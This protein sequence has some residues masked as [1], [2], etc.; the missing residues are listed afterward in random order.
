MGQPTEDLWAAGIE[1]WGSS[2]PQG[3][4][5]LRYD[6]SR[7]LEVYEINSVAKL[8]EARRNFRLSTGA[9]A[10]SAASEVECLSSVLDPVH[11]CHKAFPIYD[12]LLTSI[13]LSFLASALM[14]CFSF[15]KP[16]KDY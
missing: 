7:T 12:L 6:V 16:C 15:P 11:R 4:E 3:S 10:L 14:A 9:E 2:W 1:G 5:P 8:R 13:G